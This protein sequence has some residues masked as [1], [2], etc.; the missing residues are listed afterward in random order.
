MRRNTVSELGA[1]AFDPNI[2]C[3]QHQ[4]IIIK[5]DLKY[6]SLLIHASSSSTYL[7]K[8]KKRP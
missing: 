1:K 5:K 2:I 6:F 4:K 3:I 7:W 8:L